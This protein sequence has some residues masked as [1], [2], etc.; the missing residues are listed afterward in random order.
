MPRRIFTLILAAALVG[1]IGASTA[2]ANASWRRQEIRYQSLR[3]GS[4]TGPEVR[5]TIRAAVAR[6]HVSGGVRKA[7]SVVRCESGFNENAFNPSGCNGYGCGGVFQQH[8]G[9]WRDRQRAYNSRRW[10]LADAWHNARANIVVSVRMIHSQ[11]W[12]GWSCA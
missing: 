1:G 5:K 8:L 7:F 2:S 3:R 11:G 4:W 12:G 9:Y 6:W 10:H